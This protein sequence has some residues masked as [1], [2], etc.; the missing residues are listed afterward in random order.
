MLAPPR[1]PRR[2][3]WNFRGTLVEPSWNLTSGPPRTTPEPIWAET[4]KLPAVGEK[5]EKKKKR[6]TQICCFLL[7]PGPSTISQVHVISPAHSA[8]CFFSVMD[9]GTQLLCVQINMKP[10][11]GAPKKESL[12]RIDLLGFLLI[13]Q[14]PTPYFQERT[15]IPIHPHGQGAG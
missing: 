2:T 15:S 1:S 11:K 3:S 5:K 6:R 7:S 14:R 9:Q 8:P 12:L 13:C 4:P 10:K